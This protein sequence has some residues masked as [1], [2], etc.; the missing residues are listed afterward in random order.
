MTGLSTFPIR[1]GNGNPNTVI[2][3]TDSSNN[4]AT[5][6]IFVDNSGNYVS[7]ALDSTVNNVI[8]AVNSQGALVNNVVTSLGTDGT[9]PPGLPGGSTGVRGWLRYI[10]SLL[11]ST[12]VVSWTGQSV[13]LAASS[14]IIGKV[15]IDQTTPGTTNK[16]AI[17]GIASSGD[18]TITTGGTAQVLFSSVIPTNGFAVYNPN[19]ADILWVSDSN[20]AAING[21]G[22]MPILP[23]GGYETPPGYIPFG[24]VS[25]IGPTTGDK[26]TAR[27][28]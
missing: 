16:V 24:P 7:V 1:D 27:K 20:T 3:A 14:T 4:I 25:I 26:V 6:H 12:L 11:S 13:A 15:G 5:A 19:A 2:I 17:G 18:T 23:S 22:S 8:T 28:W 9:S 10:G 21:L